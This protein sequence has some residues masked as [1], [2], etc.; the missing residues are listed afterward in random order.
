MAAAVAVVAALPVVA[1]AAVTVVVAAMAAAISVAARAHPTQASHV[2]ILGMAHR[3]RANRVRHSRHATVMIPSHHATVTSN[4][5]KT[6][7]VRA[8]NQEARPAMTSTTSNP[9]ATPPQASRRPASPPAATAATS[10]A[11][12]PA[13]AR[14]AVVAGATGLVGRAVLARLLADPCYSAV[15]TVG[16]RAPEQQHPKL[17]AHIAKSFNDLALPPADDVFIALGTTIK[18]AGSAA[19]FRAVDFDAVVAAARVARSAGAS[20][21]GVVSAMG[22]DSASKVFYSRVKGEMEDAVAALG[23]D[24]VVIARPSLLAGDRDA[25][26]QPGRAVEK[27]SLFAINLFKPLVPANYRPVEA[28]DVAQS[29]VDAVQAANSG[30]RVMLSS[31]L[32]KSA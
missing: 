24:A 26:K 18:A 15:H 23:F 32:Q 10:A 3:P 20:R 13:A 21:L 19:A 4:N 1:M 30:T 14:V 31:E 22:A 25:L 11:D 29:L 12:A 8:P 17:T 6:R 9:P 7:A 2:K 5:T 16:R 28:D 27:M